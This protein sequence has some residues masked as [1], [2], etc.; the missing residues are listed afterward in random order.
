MILPLDRRPIIVALAGSNGA[1]KTTFFHDHLNTP[2]RLVAV[3][4]HGRALRRNPPVP[5]WLKPLLP[6]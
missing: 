6:D 5:A 1:G 4:E 2:F 3:F